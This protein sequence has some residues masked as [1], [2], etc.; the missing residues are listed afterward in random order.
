MGSSPLVSLENASTA[1]ESIH[2]DNDF[3]D[4]ESLLNFASRTSSIDYYKRDFLFRS[5]R[6]REKGVGPVA[7][8]VSP[9]HTLVIGHSDLPTRTTDVLRIRLLGKY[10]RIYAS[11]LMGPLRDASGLGVNPIPLGLSNPTN[12]SPLHPVYGK[13]S[14]LSEAWD[15]PK[16]VDRQSRE[17]QIYANFSVSTSPSHRGRLA[18]YLKGIPH[19]RWGE[20]V[21]TISGRLKYLRDIRECGLVICPRGN[22]MDTHRLWE[23]LYL[24]AI[25]VVLRSSYQYW[26][27]RKF[28][29]PAV[30]LS[31]WK[32]IADVDKILSLALSE[33][34]TEE[35]IRR[36]RLSA[37]ISKDGFLSSSRDGVNRNV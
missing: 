15:F 12:E 11:N 16:G 18:D 14:L 4:Q 29:L 10:Q 25:P 23:A 19:V 32:E 34:F 7:Q 24:G 3:F 30:G 33:G 1:L 9:G 22:G 21:P 5:G 36:L 13:H 17:P 2:A 6:W 37:W 26:I 28:G 35:G 27:C 8:L 20:S 31:I